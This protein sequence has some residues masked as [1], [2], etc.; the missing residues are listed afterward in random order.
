M[1]LSTTQSSVIPGV[2]NRAGNDPIFALNAE[3][4]R[5]A[6]EGESILNATLG[7]LMTDDGGLA[8]MP[9]VLDAFARAQGPRA[10][11]Y[12]P[13][14]GTP[15]Y[16]DAILTDL[17]GDAEL[18]EQAVAVATPGG[19][20]AVYEAVV[21]FLEEGQRM[22]TTTWYWGPYRE[23]TRHAG[24]G[25][26]T[27]SMFDGSGAFDLDALRVGLE[28]HAATQGRA[29]LVLN[30]PCHNPTGYSLSAEEWSGVAD[31][32]TAVGRRCP[33][34]VL[35]DA[36]Y[37]TFGAADARTWIDAIPPLMEQA[38]VVVAWTASKAFAQYGS[39]VGA[40]VGL[41][42]DPAELDQ[43]RNALG[44]SCRATWSNCNHLGQIAV[45]ELLTD[46]ELR[47]R[48]MRE[49]DGLIELLQERIDVFNDAAT[50]AG[51]STPRYDSGFFVSVFTPD[52]ETTAA[53][54][55]EAGVYVIPLDRAVR[56]ALCSM[57]KEQIGR[58][59]TA[60]AEGVEAA[61]P[62]G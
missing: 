37:Y 57:P 7:A 50:S 40:L 13:I 14:S 20:G 54:M 35:L 49:R 25:V 55:R 29:L 47:E 61:E 46:P 3:A 2:R 34:T 12:A 52:A 21:N 43:I 42:R 60:L 22:L 9:S 26:D 19:T 11:G 36:A 45:T 33:V 28:S 51:L 32:V 38:T 44:Y 10:A 30:F 15:G 27:F 17:F 23:I 31:I 5:R 4:F 8:V 62:T 18:R 48:S 56:V 53:T 6:A 24:R 1:T 16:R 59:V 58:L 39:R 41:H